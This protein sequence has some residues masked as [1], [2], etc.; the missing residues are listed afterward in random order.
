MGFS[1]KHVVPA[2][3]QE[4]WDWHTR[5]GAVARLTPPFVP[6]AP[7]Q[8]AERLSDG[9][10]VFGL[11]AGLR[12]T[13]RH[14]LSR[15]RSG[16][17]F[18]DVCIDAPMKKL[19]NWRH[20]HEF[21]DTEDGQCE[22]TDTLHTRVPTSM[23][24]GVFAYRQ[25]QLIDDISF[26]NR[27]KEAGLSSDDKKLTVAITGSRGGVGRNLASQLTTAGHDVIQ[28]VRSKAKP[29]QRVW[30]PHMPADDLLDG[31]DV[32][33]H[34][35]GEPIFGR[36]NDSHKASLRDSRIDPTTRL[37]E[38]V[39]KTPSVTTM[40]CASA[41]GFYGADRGDEE[42][43]EDSSVGTGF[44]AELVRDWEAATQPSKDA[45]KR[46]VNVRTGVV[47]AGNTGLLPVLRTLFSTGLGGAFGDGDFWF[48]WIAMDDLTDIYM[49]A[50]LDPTLSGP[51]NGTAPHPVTN[52][53]MAQALGKALRRPVVLPIPALGPRMLLGKEGAQELALADQKVLPAVLKSR[54][55]IFRFPT[56][57]QAF[58]H[59]LGGESLQHPVSA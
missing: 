35:A 23:V 7:I 10:T 9:T 48:S 51:I 20:D 6:M 12:W 43:E 24:E 18:T 30:N 29:Q 54:G 19:A 44:L 47:L 58:A 15:Y 4:I 59:E 46:V 32:L 45:G 36:F 22:V 28:L 16:F 53:D 11:P 42:L 2:S 25:K 49:L 39:A 38:L 41:I 3:R 26:L 27:L 33:V 13:A 5:Y 31:V 56:I 21:I 52:R 55:H 34:L 50:I 57:E 14:D 8:Q 40:V 37:A 1:A 17:S